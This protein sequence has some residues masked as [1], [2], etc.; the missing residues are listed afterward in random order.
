MPI[1][2]SCSSCQKKYR[3]PDTLGG[4][5]AKCQ[6]C[7]ALMSIPAAV[8]AAAPSTAKPRQAAAGAQARPAAK[9]AAQPAPQPA[10]EPFGLKPLP[11]AENLFVG[12]VAGGRGPDPLG[13]P[14]V[15]DY[16]F[17]D[18]DDLFDLGSTPS[19]ESDGAAYS[20][21]PVIAEQRRLEAERRKKWGG[22]SDNPYMKAAEEEVGLRTKT[23][24]GK[25]DD[26]DEQNDRYSHFDGIVNLTGAVVASASAMAIIMGIFVPLVGLV[27]GIGLVA[28]SSLIG[29]AGY[30][31]S[32]VMVFVHHK[33]DPSKG[34]MYL[35]VPFYNLYY[36][37]NYWYVVR[38]PVRMILIANIAN[39]L[40]G[41]A[42]TVAIMSAAARAAAG[43]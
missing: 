19:V 6:Q 35:F 39:M 32:V 36:W 34:I 1:D 7:G 2:V 17:Q 16:G 13:E 41:V 4:K 27:M 11:V 43:G 9:P 25:Y 20:E 30:I 15:T 42:W 29:M 26:E 38:S 40:A 12:A 5:T 10:P 22:A 3:V 21:N 14:L 31:W 8:G 28:L 23:K 37:W 24:K 33:D 18:P